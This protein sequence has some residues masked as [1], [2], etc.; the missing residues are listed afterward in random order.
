MTTT[1][2]SYKHEHKRPS[3]IGPQFF[4]FHRA[5]SSQLANCLERE[6]GDTEEGRP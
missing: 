4:D 1:L 6:E 3:L 5:L 2:T